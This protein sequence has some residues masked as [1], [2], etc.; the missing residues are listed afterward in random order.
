MSWDWYF[1][2]SFSS[3]YSKLEME[4]GMRVFIREMMM[5]FARLEIEIIEE[6]GEGNNGF[7]FLILRSRLK[8][9]DD[10]IRFE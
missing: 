9:M 5:I 1:S 10:N 2:T 4:K 3:S 7:F 6:V 8:L